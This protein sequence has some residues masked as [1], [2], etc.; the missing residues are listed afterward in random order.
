MDASGANT[1]D[2]GRRPSPEAVEAEFRRFQATGDPRAIAAVYDTVAPELLLVAAHVSR[3]PVEAEDVV[4]ATFLSA[5]EKAEQ[6]DAQRP[7][8]AWLIG[9]LIN[10]ARLEHRRE[11]RRPD[12]ARLPW[13]PPPDP[14]DAAEAAEFAAQ[15]AAILGG[16]PP[17]YRQTL[18]LRW[19]HGLSAVEIAHT[20][21][22]SPA[23]IKARLRRGQ[24]LLR[25]ALP[26]GFASAALMALGTGGGLAAM[27]SRVVARAHELQRLR[28][29]NTTSHVTA[30][31]ARSGWLQPGPRLF[32]IV[33]AA[34]VLS[35]AATWLVIARPRGADAHRPAL[36]PATTAEPTTVPAGSPAAAPEARA[37]PARSPAPGPGGLD[38]SVVWHDDAP[39]PDVW[40]S[41]MPERTP[42]AVLHERWLRTDRAGRAAYDRLAPGRYRV[43]TARGGHLSCAVKGG[44]RT[45]R[46]LV[47]PRGVVLRGHLRRSSE[48]ADNAVI[49]LTRGD[50]LDEGH[51][52]TRTDAAGYFELRDVTPDRAFTILAAGCAPR[53]LEPVAGRPGDTIPIDLDLT[54]DESSIGLSGRIVDG[55]GQPIPDALVRVGHGLEANAFE[56]PLDPE[57][58]GTDRVVPALLCHT[59]ATGAFSADGLVL[60]DRRTLVWVRAAGHAPWSDVIRFDVAQEQRTIELSPGRVLTGTVRSASGSAVPDVRI[61]VR[62]AA[63]TGARHAPRWAAAE[64][65]SD[66]DGAFR[67]VDLPRT[68][69]H[70]LAEAPDGRFATATEPAGEGPCTWDMTLQ[71]PLT[72]TGVV[73]TTAGGRLAGHRVTAQ[74]PPGRRAVSAATTDRQGRFAVEGCEDCDY[75]LEVTDPSSS[76]T[77]PLATAP[78]AN[79]QAPIELIVPGHRLTEVT[80]EGRVVDGA[81]QPIGARLV[82]NT[83][84]PGLATASSDPRTGAFRFEALPRVRDRYRIDVQGPRGMTIPTRPFALAPG[85]V[86]NLGDLVVQQPGGLKFQLRRRDGDPAGDGRATIETAAGLKQQVLVINDGYGWSRPL[87]PG[88]YVLHLLDDLPQMATPFEIRAGQ[89]TRRR[90]RL[91]AGARREFTLNHPDDGG[92]L[93]FEITWR[94]GDGQVLCHDEHHWRAP[95]PARIVQCFAPGA[96]RLEVRSAAGRRA[97]AEFQIPADDLSPGSLT[98]DLRP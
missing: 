57:H 38:L 42:H 97:A 75:T 41:V 91:P 62:A 65:W 71:P 92:P 58:L 81:G 61:R 27:R 17:H 34:L 14:S 83:L 37:Q 98:L 63:P 76:W 13:R 50:N 44:G 32:G 48:P 90:L 3:S 16:L 86:T 77:G 29:G 64:C 35:I 24:D 8:M 74:A 31:S 59:D 20:L 55:Q 39:A 70:L 72:L 79:P 73:R 80:V 93:C 67:V 89:V 96:Y 88:R 9:I 18:T 1:D 28:S 51:E 95:L 45:R 46:R 52:A 78:A 43:T 40:I 47:I 54:A 85:N 21:G 69:L 30:G 84:A 23:T 36:P 82:L 11:Q 33:A 10:Q 5:M 68:P 87:A 25:E 4:Q 26:V 15:L 6:Y 94:D 2:L 53:P 56:V 19:V 12:P 66:A 60:F 22:I 49:W 7:L